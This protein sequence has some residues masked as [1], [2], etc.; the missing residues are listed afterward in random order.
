MNSTFELD[1]NIIINSR[2]R[3][4]HIQREPI[5]LFKLFSGIDVVENTIL[6]TVHVKATALKMNVRIRVYTSL[7]LKFLLVTYV[8][9]YRKINK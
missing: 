6:I 4:Q 2:R 5:Q 9:S 7:F 1:T 3:K 8:E